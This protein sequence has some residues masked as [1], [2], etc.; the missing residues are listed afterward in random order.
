MKFTIDR[1]KWYRGKT[2]TAS[3]LLRPQD[4]MMC[5]LGQMAL[6]CGYTPEQIESITEP[7]AFPTVEKDLFPSYILNDGH[8]TQTCVRMM[9]I[10]DRR[11]IS[12]SE[13]EE[14]LKNEVAQFGDELEFVN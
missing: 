8:Q 5:C 6:Q 1:T 9:D 12:D 4:G 14:R 11:D 2:A 10:N 7:N 3:A 13:R